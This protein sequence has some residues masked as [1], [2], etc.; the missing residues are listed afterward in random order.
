[1]KVIL[2]AINAKYIHSNLAVFS[3]KKYA[4][5]YKES[6]SIAEYTINQYVDDILND[7]Y[8]K[9]PD[10]LALSCYIWNIDMVKE[11]TKELK[12][13]C[14][15]LLIWVG[16]PEVSYEVDS[17]LACN[18]QID[19]VMIG[20][21]EQTFLELME[22]YIGKMGALEDINGIAYRNQQEIF[23]TKPRMPM[24]ISEIPFPYDD[25]DMLEHKIIYYE[26]SRG[27]PFSCSYC[28]S[29][30][31]KGVRLRKMDLVKQELQMFLDYKVPQ[32][33]FIDRTFN[34]NHVHATEIWKYLLE[35]D[36]GVTNFH[37]EVSADLLNEEEL[38]L[39]SQMRVGLIQLEIGV[40]ST[41]SRTIQA[42]H[43]KMNL[44]KLTKAVAKVKQ[45]GNIHQHLDLIAG[46]PYEDY[47]S[48]RNSFNEVYAMEPEQLQLGFLKVLKGS[49][50]HREYEA[51]GMKYR[52]YAPYEVLVTKWLP[53]E[54]VLRLKRVENM[55]E[56]YY[57]SGQFVHS[58]RY[59]MHHVSSP[60]DFYEQL[61]DYYDEKQ[62]IGFVH[63]RI[64]RY[65][66]LLEFVEKTL[67]ECAEPLRELL[68]YDL[69]LR[70][71][72]KTRPPFGV[73][74]EPFK[75]LYYQFFKTAEQKNKDGEENV[76]H[77]YQGYQ[78]R[79][80]VRMTH[81]E[82]FTYNIEELQKSGCA[83]KEDSHVLFDYKKR[84]PLTMEATTTVIS[85]SGS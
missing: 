53:F 15:E 84:H 51:H 12:K 54:D 41:N 39:M 85:V 66:I 79:Q 67:P 80:M 26:T 37:F 81:V 20:E 35:H 36:N 27:C 24:D 9:R 43:R 40:Q 71:N 83:I 61:G 44:E 34:C 47:Q 19:G 25:I 70:E 55:V 50:M 63:A 82:P 64:A 7:L 21:G 57:N 38:E 74:L 3:L 13:V 62:I 76:L 73:D 22:Y 42:I 65:N 48:F 49:K 2:A 46:L 58:L 4:E 14:P 8:Q 69:Y 18:P 23:F 17:F 32:V 16:G 29:S 68:V 6:V 30:I 59:L 33:K 52:D 5:K 77:G 10:V 1:M 75:E 11:L 28:L 78:A 60:F 72:M 56:V 45:L 31:E